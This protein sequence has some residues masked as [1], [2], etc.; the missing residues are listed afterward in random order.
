MPNSG[1]MWVTLP[2][3]CERGETLNQTV[4]L[5]EEHLP[6]HTHTPRRGCIHNTYQ[7]QASYTQ[8]EPNLEA[9]QKVFVYMWRGSLTLLNNQASAELESEIYDLCFKNLRL[10]DVL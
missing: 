9:P 4:W 2:V 1:V 6:T 5:K 7:P 10:K 3:T 8:L